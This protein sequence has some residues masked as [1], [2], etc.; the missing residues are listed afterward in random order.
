MSK[1]YNTQLIHPDPQGNCN[2][3]Q[4]NTYTF[5]KQIG[6]QVQGFFDIASTS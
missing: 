3:E 4:G 5:Q 6:K 1:S 2:V